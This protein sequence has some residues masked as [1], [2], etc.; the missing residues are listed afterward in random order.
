MSAH[1]YGLLRQRA[2]KRMQL[3]CGVAT[4]AGSHGANLKPP[5]PNRPQQVAGSPPRSDESVSQ[6]A[7]KAHPSEAPAYGGFKLAA[8]PHERHDVAWLSKP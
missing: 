7:M 2:G 3:I 4:G 8:H 6:Q 5:P 1:S